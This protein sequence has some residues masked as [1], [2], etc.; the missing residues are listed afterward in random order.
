[1]PNRGYDLALKIR[2]KLL[3]KEHPQYALLL[4]SLGWLH[5]YS[6]RYYRAERYFRQAAA[7]YRKAQGERGDGYITSLE[8][9]RQL[10]DRLAEKWRS[11][12]ISR[13]LA[14]PARSPWL[15]P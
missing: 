4:N 12:R 13:R 8:N 1:M 10:F 9:L 3:G 6:G 5:L 7:T 15:S 2:K 11:G 14:R